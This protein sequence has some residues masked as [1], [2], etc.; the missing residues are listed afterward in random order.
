MPN[1]AE[2]RVADLR[3]Q[4]APR[5]EVHPRVRDAAQPLAILMI[6][7]PDVAH[8]RMAVAEMHRVGIGDDALG[9][10]GFA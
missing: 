1:T 6:H 10:A 3:Q 5:R 4:I 8:R 2:K 7:V 9:G